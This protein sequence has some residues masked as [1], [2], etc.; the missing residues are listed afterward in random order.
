[1]P[2]WKNEYPLPKTR[3][4]EGT[5][6]TGQGQV[7]WLTGLYFVLLFG[8]LLCTQLQVSAYRSA[9]LYLEDALAASNL[10]SAVIDMEEYG[11]SH[12]ILIK[13][14]LD[15]YGRYCEA[16]KG[17]LQLDDNWQGGNRHLISGSVTVEKY[18]IYN[19][20]GASVTV[21]RVDKNVCLQ[22]S[23]GTLGA[24]LA[25]NGTPVTTTGVY[26]E[27]SFMVEGILG[28]NVKA[29]KGKLVDVVSMAE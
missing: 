2:F 4:C 19:V 24:V 26:S 3:H 25:P 6:R 10:A 15:A 5:P 1:M 14:P 12:T 29:H 23:A 22:T 28:V 20:D 9:S 16:V 11:I 13:D 27:I 17:N 18:I 7:E 8:I 21:H